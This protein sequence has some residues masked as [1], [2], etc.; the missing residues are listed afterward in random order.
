MTCAFPVVYKKNFCARTCGGNDIHKV[1][2]SIINIYVKFC[3]R[4][5]GLKIIN[6]GLL[7][8]GFFRQVSGS[9]DQGRH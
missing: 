4:N 3:L 7:L 1:S 6:S 9:W 8:I 2:Q 5:S